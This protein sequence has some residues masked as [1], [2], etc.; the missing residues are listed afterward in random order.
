M[1]LNRITKLTPTGN[2]MHFY[3][4]KG[5]LILSRNG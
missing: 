1:H 4:E 5:T 3:L 2:P